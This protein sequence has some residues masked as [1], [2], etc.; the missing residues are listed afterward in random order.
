MADA[1]AVEE[2]TIVAKKGTNGKIKEWYAN[3]HKNGD[4]VRKVIST[5]LDLENAAG[6]IVLGIFLPESQ[7]VV[8][9]IQKASKSGRL[10]MYDGMKKCVDKFMEYEGEAP[11]NNQG[12]LSEQ[13]LAKIQS[14]AQ[15]IVDERM[16]AK[17]A[18]AANAETAVQVPVNTEAMSEMQPTMEVAPEMMTAPEMEVEGVKSL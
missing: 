17:K 16:A 7:G 10:A 8:P 12:L 4:G 14:T 9:S 13:E 6:A 5:M 11:Q 1:Q 2:S 15:N 3:A 18:A